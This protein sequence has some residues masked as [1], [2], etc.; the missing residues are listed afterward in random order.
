MWST[1]P[2]WFDVKKKRVL[3]LKNG[4]S[5]P[6]NGCGESVPKKASRSRFIL[7]LISWNRLSIGGNPWLGLFDEFPDP[8]EDMFF[9]HK[10]NLLNYNEISF[11]LLRF[12]DFF[13]WKVFNWDYWSTASTLQS[14]CVTRSDQKVREIQIPVI[15]VFKTCFSIKGW[16]YSR[17]SHN[18]G[19]FVKVKIHDLV[20]FLLG[21]FWLWGMTQ[22]FTIHSGLS[23]SSCT[24]ANCMK[25][26]PKTLNCVSSLKCI[27]SY[28]SH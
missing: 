24:M 12:D 25:N 18:Y 6:K 27:K 2:L 3:T 4:D 23:Q 19:Y 10:K 13:F 21:Q 1:E 8:E 22:S 17:K 26:R 14:G 16:N 15:H 7:S 28:W 11:Q 5:R 20:A 9:C